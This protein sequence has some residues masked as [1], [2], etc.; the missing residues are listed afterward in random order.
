[1]KASTIEAITRMAG[2]T[3]A[4]AWRAVFED[5]HDELTEM[6]AAHG[7]RA[8]GVWIQ[9][10]MLPV[11]ARLAEDGY[12][13]KPGFNRKDSVENWGPPEERER[14]AWYVVRTAD[15]DALG[16]MVLQVY[17]SHRSFRLPCAPR[18]LALEATERE[19]IVAALSDPSFRI[20]WDLPQERLPLKEPQ[21]ETARQS[22][23]YATDTSFGD[24]L[25]PGDDGQLHGWNLDDALG[26]WGRY[27]WEL[28]SV[29]PAS[30]RLVAFF[31][32]PCSD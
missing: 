22:F 8:Y 5:R 10:F 18:L 24:G 9:R 3:L 15:G 31:R 29:V 32:R 30:G 11:A 12:D 23:E 2:E 1:M 25:K 19:A 20:R 28:V 4:R 7:D 14:C 21:G 26:R 17:H 16:T 27:G 13:I 6:F